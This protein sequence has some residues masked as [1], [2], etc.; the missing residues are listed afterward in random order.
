MPD[1]TPHSSRSERVC[2]TCDVKKP[3][4]EFARD[5]RNH[6]GLDGR[7]QKCANERNYE[8][9]R[10]NPAAWAAT[11][12]RHNRRT[13]SVAVEDLPPPALRPKWTAEE[14]ALVLAREMTD[15]ELADVLHR[16]RAAIANRRYRLK[17]GM[18]Q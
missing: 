15:R 16:S 12:K 8:R 6:D 13:G 4:T 7:C 9:R 5:R 18:P 2:A 3:A 1:R 17:K 14:D 11:M 10:T